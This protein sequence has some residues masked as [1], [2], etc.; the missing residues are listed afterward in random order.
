M[1]I[2]QKGG[3]LSLERIRVQSPKF[4]ART[5][6]PLPVRIV[7]AEPVEERLALGLLVEKRAKVGSDEREDFPL[8]RFFVRGRR[9]CLREVMDWQCVGLIHPLGRLVRRLSP[10]QDVIAIPDEDLRKSGKGFERV[11]RFAE[12]L[13]VKK[14]VAATEVERHPGRH[15]RPT[16]RAR[17]SADEGI[18]EHH[19][20]AANR[21]QRRCFDHIIQSR[22]V[23]IAIDARVAAPVVRKAKQDVGSCFGMSGKAAETENACGQKS[24]ERIEGERFHKSIRPSLRPVFWEARASFRSTAGVFCGVVRWLT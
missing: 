9:D 12:F 21:I 14:G 22:P 3:Q 18:V 10:M 20:A 5:S 23:R 7:R 16:R 24:S 13:A 17:W 15:R 8:S 2:R 11:R 19:P 4:L 1:H 6:G